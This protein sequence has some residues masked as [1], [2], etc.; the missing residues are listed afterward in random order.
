MHDLG[1]S[2]L[3][4]LCGLTH[5]GG[6]GGVGPLISSFT[7][8]VSSL[9][10]SHMHIFCESHDGNILGVGQTKLEKRLKNRTL[11][12]V[13]IVAVSSYWLPTRG[14]PVVNKSIP[15]PFLLSLL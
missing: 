6:G 3:A 10:A 15:L 8:L 13:F 2:A 14:I 5:V 1:T 12:M 7:G 11:C 4:L 9:S